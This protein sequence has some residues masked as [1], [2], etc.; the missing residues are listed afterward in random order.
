MMQIQMFT[1]PGAAAAAP[2]ERALQAGIDATTALERQRDTI[3]QQVGGVGQFDSG[4]LLRLQAELGDYANRTALWA[5]LAH[6]LTA[7]VETLLRA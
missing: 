1:Q 6:K 3:A 4:Q 7:T 5:W 2:L